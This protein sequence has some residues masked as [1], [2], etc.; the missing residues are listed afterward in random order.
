MTHQFDGVWG[1]C[2]ATIQPAYNFMIYDV[3]SLTLGNHAVVLTLLVSV[4]GYRRGPSDIS[5]D[6]AVVRDD[7]NSIHTSSISTSSSSAAPNHT[8]PVSISPLS[9]DPSPQVRVWVSFIDYMLLDLSSY[10]ALVP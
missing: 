1:C 9:T 6:Y 7:T 5:F 4:T 8:S 2:S 10:L 3:A